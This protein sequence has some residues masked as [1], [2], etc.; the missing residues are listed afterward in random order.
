MFKFRGS[1]CALR[2][3][4]NR[5]L[6]VPIK[7]GGLMEVNKLS[8]GIVGSLFLAPLSVR[9]SPYINCFKKELEICLFR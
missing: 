8:M 2:S 9:Q 5:L 1:S 4:N 6:E 7:T 3:C